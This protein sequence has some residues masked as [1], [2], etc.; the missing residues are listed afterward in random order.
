MWEWLQL[1]IALCGWL[2]A[3]SIVMFIGSLIAVPWLIVRVPADYF[4]R[5]GHY[6]DRWKP[7]HPWLRLAFL[8]AK[9]AVGLILLIAG[10]IM[11]FIPGQ[12]VLT[13]LAGLL[14]LDFPGKFACERRLISSPPVFSA[15]NWLRAKAGKPPLE[16]PQVTDA[17]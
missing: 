6:A 15:V 8:T 1:H 5:Q 11:L 9:N 10:I 4:L 12:G 16:R 13:I 7:R 17:G 2:F 3:A 14:F